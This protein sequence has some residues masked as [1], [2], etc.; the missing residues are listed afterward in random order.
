MR[1]GIVL[2]ILVA[3]LIGCKGM[4]SSAQNDSFAG[5]RCIV[6]RNQSPISTRA[7][8]EI[9]DYADHGNALCK[10]ILGLMYESGESVSQDFSKARALYQSAADIDNAAYYRLGRMAEN[11]IGEPADY[12][13]ARQLYQRTAGSSAYVNSMS[14]LAG[15]L[16]NG[17]GGPQDRDGALALYLDTVSYAGDDAWDNVQRLRRTGLTLSITQANR[18]NKVWA[19]SA[20][21]RIRLRTTRLFSQ[22]QTLAISNPQLKP[23]TLRLDYTPGIAASGVSLIE[24]SGDSAF[25]KRA[26]EVIRDIRFTDEP[27]MPEGQK[28]WIVTVVIN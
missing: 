14:Q 24:S 15:L 21:N 17:K 7:I 18:Y 6:L 22:W 3:L 28:S 1:R 5:L 27:I 8:S 2:L 10:T 12:V 13:K 25:D 23:A 11:G 20:K 26:M 9:G 19:R 16:E 4:D